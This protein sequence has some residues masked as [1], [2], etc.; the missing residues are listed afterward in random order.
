M[1][2]SCYFSYFSCYLNNIGYGEN[3]HSL[4]DVWQDDIKNKYFCDESQQVFPEVVVISIFSNTLGDTKS[5][6]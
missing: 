1:Y 6:I 2:F 4:G 3:K 5:A